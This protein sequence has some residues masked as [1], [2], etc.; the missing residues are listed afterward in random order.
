MKHTALA[1]LN[2]AVNTTK[3]AVADCMAQ[4]SNVCPEDLQ[5]M[6]ESVDRQ[7]GWLQNQI[8]GL[9]RT[10][11]SHLDGHLPALVGAERM[12]KALKALGLAGDFDVQKKV[13]YANS[14]ERSAVQFTLDLR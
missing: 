13:I 5:C 9:Y 6:K 10:F 2:K 12:S 1:S 11:Y 8:D 7:F 3:L 14:G 4:T